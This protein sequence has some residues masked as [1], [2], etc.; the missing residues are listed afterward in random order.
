MRS[1]RQFTKGYREAIAAVDPST[2]AAFAADE[3]RTFAQTEL[4]LAYLHRFLPTDPVNTVPF[5][6]MGY[7]K[8]LDDTTS[9]AAEAAL[10]SCSPGRPSSSRASTCIP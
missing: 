9:E 5:L 6:M 10:M 4:C 3:V 2:R 8:L 1:D 7:P